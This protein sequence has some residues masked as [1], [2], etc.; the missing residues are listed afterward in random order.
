MLKAIIFDF[1][2]IIAD[3]EPTHLEA[4][5]RVLNG[6]DISLTDEAYYDKYL[7]YDDK[8]L[9]K[10]ILKSN[11]KEPDEMVVNALIKEKSLLISELFREYVVLFPGFKEYLNR[12]KDNYLLAIGSGALKSEILMVLK[13]F[14]IENDF[15]AL[16]TADDVVNCKPDPEVFIKS[17]HSLNQLI[18]AKITPG[19]CLVIEDSIYGIIA[20][21]SA[22]MKC[23]AITNTYNEKQLQDADLIVDNFN[24]LDMNSI[25]ELFI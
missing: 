20:A 12:I 9:F 19:E 6:I 21:K 8:T 13:K 17:L 1:D 24:E 2:G 18:N 7:A 25:E 11:N 3:T 15:Q 14:N 22:K 5:K 4:F 16:A 10:E 23:V